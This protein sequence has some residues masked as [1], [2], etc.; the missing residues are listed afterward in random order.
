MLE[1]LNVLVG[2]TG[3]LLLVVAII[4]GVIVNKYL[5]TKK[6]AALESINNDKIRTYVDLLWG[7]VESTVT[8]LNQT[9]VDGL[10][11]QSADGTLTEDDAKLVKNT[12]IAMVID[13]FNSESKAILS[14]VFEDLE[15]YVD[16][17]IEAAV[18]R[19]KEQNPIG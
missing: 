1:N 3:G 19:A 11:A 6:S 18:K 15:K 10:K 7:T 17:L 2:T 4:V 13:S 14:L 9:M 12:A 8:S 5:N 16:T